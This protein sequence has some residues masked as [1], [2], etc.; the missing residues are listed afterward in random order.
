MCKQAEVCFFF[1]LCIYG[2]KLWK[3]DSEDYENIQVC[4]II[5]V[6]SDNINGFSNKSETFRVLLN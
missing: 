3:K 1:L 4:K 5:Y 6:D 2:N